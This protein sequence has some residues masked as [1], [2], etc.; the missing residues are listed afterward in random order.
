MARLP[1]GSNQALV[2]LKAVDDAYPLYGK[3]ES[4]AHGTR[5]PT[6]LADHERKP[7]VRVA[8]PSAAGAARHSGSATRSCSAMRASRITGTIDASRTLCQTGSVSRR[9]CWLSADALA[10]SGLVQTGSLVEHVYKMKLD[11]PSSVPALRRQAEEK[12][13]SGRLVDP[14]QPERAHRR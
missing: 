4:R 12:F 14:D 7:M 1:D 9:A 10:A 8:A 13:P 2:E 11:D 6:L 5:S 3:L